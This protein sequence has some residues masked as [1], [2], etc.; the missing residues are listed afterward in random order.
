MRLLR[1]FLSKKAILFDF[2]GVLIDSDSFHNRSKFEAVKAAGIHMDSIEW[3]TI[4][5]YST[6]QIYEKLSN[7]FPKKISQ[8]KFLKSKT[9][10]FLKFALKEIELFPKA[11]DF[12][13]LM[14]NNG[15]KTALVSA[16]RKSNLAIFLNKFN[17]KKYF[18]V[19]ITG[20]DINKNKPHPESY[21]KAM[22]LLNL[23]P[24]DCLVVED[25][26]LGVTSGRLAGCIVIGK[27]STISKKEL[28]AAGASHTF[29]KF[30]IFFKNPK[31]LQKPFKKIKGNGAD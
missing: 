21:L 17:L 12:V 9:D 14:K 4:Q 18:D 11:L 19:L 2:D 22:T 27:I 30:E 26:Q 23:K 15:L 28:L 25:N 6:K 24:E 1:F 10:N 31:K 7:K 20:D 16:T 5:H 29:D 3:Q 13:A 8:K